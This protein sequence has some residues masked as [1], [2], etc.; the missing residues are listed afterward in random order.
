MTLLDGLAVLDLSGRIAGAYCTK[1]LADAGAEVHKVEPPGGDPLRR[2]VASGHQL[3]PGEDGAL[4]AYLCASKTSSVCDLDDGAGRARLAELVEASDV[5]VDTFSPAER[6]RVGLVALAAR[7]PDLVQ[8]AITDFGLDGPWAGRPATE[9]T[10]QAWCGSTGFRG[11]P[12]RAPLSVGGQVGEYVGG[13]VGAIGALAARRRAAASGVGELVDV[14]LLECM[15]GALQSFEW[16]HVALM[17]LKGFSRSVE[18]PSVERAK[19]GW[20]GFT[21]VT[22]Q[23]WEDFAVMVDQPTLVDDPELRLQLGRWPRRDEVYGLIRPWLRARTVDEIVELATLLRIPVAEVGNGATVVGQ[24]HFAARGV[25][26]ENPAGFHQPRPPFR[27]GDVAP[28]RLSAAPRLGE[29]DR[30]GPRFGA[31]TRPA[32]PA[33]AGPVRPALDGVRV[34]DFTAFWAGPSASHLLAALGA[35]VIKVESVQR[36]DGMRFAGG[37]RPGVE[38]WWEIGWVFHGVNV[39]K[40]DVTLDLSV[41]AGRELARRLIA[42]ADVVIENFSPRVMDAFDLGW[43][44]LSALNPRLLMVRMPAFGL[45]GPWRDRVGFAPTMEQ[46]S[47]MAWITGYEDGEPVAPRGSCDPLSGYHAVFTL[48][49]ALEW[50]QRSSTGAL[51]ELPMIEV[52]LNVTAG[53][54]AEY[55]RYG[56]LLARRGNRG[57]QGAPQNVYRAAGDDRWLALC[58]ADDDQ[59]RALRA[60]MGDPGWAADPALSTAAG[61][62]VAADRVDDEIAR[63]LAGA[64]PDE[65][66]GRL[67]EAGV[68]AAPVVL[69]PDVVENEQL[70]ARGFFEALEHPVTGQNLYARPPW[71]FSG[72]RDP[73]RRPPPTLGQHNEEVLVGELGLTPEE[74]AALVAAGVVGDRPAGL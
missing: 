45:D 26:V 65:V 9:F 46:I 58:V 34:V 50:R 51:V 11:L 30:P 74:L 73:S 54:V 27:V 72:R 15:V 44:A 52:A 67:T 39:G 66:L 33:D 14:S 47:G 1:L 24:D 12:D 35:D 53:Q 43:E 70:A 19:D 28:R 16:L 57:P 17:D 60:V 8:V 23:Q 21:M 37:Q 55:E 31:R 3:A 61:R 41:P 49:A 13:V 10:L 22:G 6:A 64:D 7:R 5:V 68:P 18:V 25:F 2:W 36:P 56:E 48:L 4:F 69:P 63:W 38:R 42:G 40:R 62:R 29:A 32:A 20:V 59:W 71:T